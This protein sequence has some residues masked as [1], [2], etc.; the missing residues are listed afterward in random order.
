MWR[1]WNFIGLSTLELIADKA[2]KT[3]AFAGLQCWA[4][5]WRDIGNIVYVSSSYFPGTR[6]SRDER[7]YKVS[8]ALATQAS[9]P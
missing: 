3:G 8:G 6:G 4:L 1:C 7:L 5:I 2:V 9:A